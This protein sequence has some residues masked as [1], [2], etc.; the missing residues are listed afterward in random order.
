[1][2]CVIMPCPALL[3]LSIS[4]DGRIW[5]CVECDLCCKNQ[6][7][8]RFESN[9]G[10][11]RRKRRCYSARGHAAFRARR[12]PGYRSCC[13]SA[14]QQYIFSS[15]PCTKCT[16]LLLM[17]I[18]RGPPPD[19]KGPFPFGKVVSVARIK[20]GISSWRQPRPE[21]LVVVDLHTIDD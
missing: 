8:L 1:M 18:T 13:R 21:N 16:S 4:N 11:S 15:S 17:I 3:E 9:K 19:L 2:K 10:T 5:I 6:D 20:A 14:C 12:I 7:C